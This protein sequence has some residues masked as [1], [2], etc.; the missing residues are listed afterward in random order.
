MGELSI[1]S[2]QRNDLYRSSW[3]CLAIFHALIPVARQLI[4]NVAIWRK[5]ICTGVQKWL[6]HNYVREHRYALAQLT[7]LQILKIKRETDTWSTQAGQPTKFFYL[8]DRHFRGSILKI[9]YGNYLIVG[10]HQSVSWKGL[11]K[12]K[13]KHSESRAGHVIS[14]RMLT[15]TLTCSDDKFVGIF[16]EKSP[17]K[18]K[19]RTPDN[20]QIFLTNDGLRLLFGKANTQLYV[21][22]REIFHLNLRDNFIAVPNV[23]LHLGLRKLGHSWRLDTGKLQ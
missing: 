16:L 14:S 21:L 3:L 15:T 12:H 8:M 20:A 23:L 1:I 13:L 22:L 5:K 11:A 9:I 19:I 4:V 10:F 2:S 7:K 18:T 17:H 6:N